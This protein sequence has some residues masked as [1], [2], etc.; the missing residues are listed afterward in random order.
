VER[1]PVTLG[2]RGDGLMEVAGGLA[3]GEAVVSP[4]AGW[5]DPGTRVRPRLQ[6]L[7]GAGRAL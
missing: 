7:P 5:I 4:A 6:P 2:L 1:R 3:A